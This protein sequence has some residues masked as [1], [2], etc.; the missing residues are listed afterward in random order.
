[1]P[2][3]L[4]DLSKPLL[5]V[6]RAI[7][8]GG[9]DQPPILYTMTE[10]RPAVLRAAEITREIKAEP[11]AYLAAVAQWALANSQEFSEVH[12]TQFPGRFAG[13]AFMSEAWALEGDGS[14]NAAALKKRRGD[15]PL[16]EH[17]D[18]IEMRQVTVVDLWGRVHMVYRKRGSKPEHLANYDGGDVGGR[19]PEA[20]RKL[21][22][23]V[24][25]HMPDGEQFVETLES[26]LITI[27]DVEVR[28][29]V[30]AARRK[31]DG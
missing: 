2:E 22:L 25:R 20:L 7:H 24:V 30:R 3:T 14:E 29:D 23:A 17:P 28:A 31:A 4:P 27:P 21:N 9:W 15:R 11:G 18:R 5:D 13:F 6:E 26:M 10:I 19:V 16:S 8:R 12:R 1:M